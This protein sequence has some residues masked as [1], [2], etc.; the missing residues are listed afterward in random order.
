M[1]Y[2]V[3]LPCTF[4]IVVPEVSTSNLASGAPDAKLDVE[5]SGTTILKVQGNSTGYVN[6]AILLESNYGRFQRGL[7]VFMNHD[8]GDVEWYA[9]NPYASPDQYIIARKSTSTHSDSTSE[10]R[11]ALLVVDRSGNV[12]ADGFV[13]GSQLCIGNSCRTTCCSARVADT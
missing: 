12:T 6:A 13:K 5:T 2:P 8:A 9:G 3:L 7:G 10:T 4:N 11:N 1:T